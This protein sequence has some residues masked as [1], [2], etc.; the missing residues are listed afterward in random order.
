MRRLWA[1]RNI[2]PPRLV[3]TADALSLV[4]GIVVL[5]IFILAA[6]ALSELLWSVKKGLVLTTRE[7]II[8]SSADRPWGRGL[9]PLANIVRSDM[10]GKGTES[11]SVNIDNLRQGTADLEAFVR[12]LDE[13]RQ[14][15]EEESLTQNERVEKEQTSTNAR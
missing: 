8:L 11:Q 5:T 1:E 6:I 9:I 12:K 15:Q 2:D 4:L 13:F 14:S 7:A 3:R 10:N